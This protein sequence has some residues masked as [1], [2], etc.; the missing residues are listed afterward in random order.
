[1]WISPVYMNQI[2]DTVDCYKSRLWKEMPILQPCLHSW[3]SSRC[4]FENIFRFKWMNEIN[5][6]IAV[7]IWCE[8]SPLVWFLHSSLC[9]LWFS[10]WWI[11]QSA[12]WYHLLWRIN[13]W[14]CLENWH[15]Q[16]S[17]LHFPQSKSFPLFVAKHTN[18]PLYAQE[19][20]S[21]NIMGYQRQW[22]MMQL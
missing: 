6:K 13:S 7:D 16:I 20:F 17:A 4:F 21:W 14:V 22:N 9:S 2:H 1:M 18:A 3:Y 5:G 10:E 12:Q 8:K 15:R 11:L 19:T